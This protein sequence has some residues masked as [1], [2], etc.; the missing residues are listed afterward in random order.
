MKDMNQ[1]KTTTRG[2]KMTKKILRRDFFKLGAAATSILAAPSL[3]ARKVWAAE[4]TPISDSIVGEVKDGLGLDYS[5][6]TGKER[7]AIPSACW[8]CVARDG[9]ICHVEDG[10]LVNIEGNPKL[11]RT[12]GKICAKGQAG[13]NQVYDPDRLLFPMK[14]VGARGEGKWK[15]ISWDDAVKEIGG[16]LKKIKDDGHPEKFAFHYG[17]M[18]A[19]ASKLIKSYFLTGFGTKTVGNHTSICES[20]KWTAQEFIWGKHYDVNDIFD[21]KTRKARSKYILIIGCNPME[22]HTSH[23]P[24]RQRLAGAIA[25]GVKT[26]TVDVRLSNTAA[27]STEWVPIKPGTDLA[28]V[29]AMMYH[30]ID[31]GLVPAAGKE[32][33]N[34][35]TGTTVAELTDFLTKPADH[36]PDK[37]KGEQPAGGYTPAWAAG[38]TGIAEAKIMELAEEYAKNSPGSTVISYRGATQHYNGVQCERAI[39][40]LEALAGN[41]DVPGGRVH[42]VGAPWSY[43]STYKLP[44]TK[45]KGLS[46]LKGEGFPFPSHSVS[47]Q[48]LEQIKKKADAGE[49]FP[50]M[51]MWYCYTPVFANGDM[52]GSIDILK[53]EKYIPYSVCV[54]TSYDE[55]AALADILLPDATYLER[56]DWEDMVSYDQLPEFYIR[57]PAV[58]PVGDVRDF[59]D[60]CYDLAVAIG[61]KD[62]IETMKFKTAKEF[63]KAACNDTAAVKKAGGF[64]YMVEH[65]ALVDPDAKP[66][67]EGYKSEVKLDIVN[68]DDIKD[69]DTKSYIFE[70]DEGVCWETTKAKY[71]DYRGTSSAYSK[72]KGQKVDGKYYAGFT[73]DKLN[74]SGLFEIKS[75]LLDGKGWGLWPA[76]MAAPE[77]KSLASDELILTNYKIA[78]QIH[79]RSQNCKYLT[80]LRPNEPAWINAKTAADLGIKDGDEITIEAKGIDNAGSLIKSTKT[81]MKTPVKVTEAVAPGVIAM[82]HHF[83]H[84]EYGRYASGNKN[85]LVD[86]ADAVKHAE[87]DPDAALLWWDNFGKRPNWIMP[88]AGDPIAGSFRFN[89]LVVKVK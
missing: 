7:K 42:A 40:T 19:S 52:Q 32:F 74:K 4:G 78:T 53:S 60:V 1:N 38:V 11:L 5:P 86:D 68:P 63:V 27:S 75:P 80:E 25:D 51:Y 50:D 69:D 77:H 67:Y 16:R 89:D 15:R 57:Q 83:G 73:P 36:V 87:T 82:A 21:V 8:Q 31:K 49:D 47:H 43:K 56:W 22:T 71:K 35:W 29:L 41:V 54:N 58:D 61:D 72:Y 64:D 10:R 17:R 59:K 33:V 44:T 12:N 26:V 55:S 45:T 24:L 70:D 62:L 39:C 46:I 2:F 18:K 48:V 9:I 76:W 28:L 81:S 37:I 23:I 30:I 84:W 20:A 34:K 14:R 13:A 85:P 3:L 66:K 88:N 79:S 65:G 6:T